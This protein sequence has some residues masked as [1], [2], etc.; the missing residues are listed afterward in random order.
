M[1]GGRSGPAFRWRGTAIGGV[2]G[3]SEPLFG[4]RFGAQFDLADSLFTHPG[5]QGLRPPQHAHGRRDQQVGR[6]TEVQPRHHPGRHAPVNFQRPFHEQAPHGLLVAPRAGLEPRG[7]RSVG[8]EDNRAHTPEG[9]VGVDDP[10]QPQSVVCR[11]DS[12]GLPLGLGGP[13]WTRGGACGSTREGIG[14]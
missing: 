2:F 10:E 6:P 9:L 1:A 13:G 14:E 12:Q 7:P 4:S 11:V 3:P 8:G 5:G